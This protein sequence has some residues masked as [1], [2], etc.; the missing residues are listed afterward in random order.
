MPN[1][2]RPNGFRPVMYANGAPWNGAFTTYLVPSSQG[3]DIFV[4]DAVSLGGTSGAD[5]GYVYGQSVEGMTTITHVA[6]PGTTVACG[7]VI[8]F[9]PIQTNLERMYFEAS[10]GVAR[11]AYVVDDP[12]VLFE[13]EEDADTTPI[14]QASLG[15]NVNYVAGTGNTTTGVSGS[16]LD[17]STV[18]TANTL[19]LKLV[20]MVPRPDN[21]LYASTG[22]SVAAR[23]LVRWNVHQNGFSVAGL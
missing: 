9:S 13:V 4:G 3:T 10:D 18:N 6:T 19:H 22:N 15:L 12:N 11:L 20:R 16:L 21:Q 2:S 1:V 8:G 14:A 7:V 17:S 5:G 23:F